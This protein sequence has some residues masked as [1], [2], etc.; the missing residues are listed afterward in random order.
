MLMSVSPQRAAEVLR[1]DL[2]K[3][4][5][6]DEGDSHSR[7]LQPPPL[8]TNLQVFGVLIAFFLLVRPMPYARCP[9]HLMLT[10]HRVA[11]WQVVERARMDQ[12]LS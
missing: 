11:V 9:E 5:A 1:L 7:T 10:H 2:L 3:S 8:T 12:E 4:L 6:H